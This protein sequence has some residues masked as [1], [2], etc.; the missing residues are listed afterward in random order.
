MAFKPTKSQ[1][2]AIYAS[3]GTL[4][5]AAAGSGKTAV[6]AERVVH[7]LTNENPISA[8]RILVVTFMSAAA[9]EMRSR[10]E[11]RLNKEFAANPDNKFIYSQK[12][13]LNNAKICTIDSFCID[14][15]REHF[16]YFEISPDFKIGDDSSVKKISDSVLNEILNEEFE[17]GEPEFLALLNALCSRFDETDLKSAIIGLYDFSENLPFPKVWLKGLS[18]NLNREEYVAKIFSE[19]FGIINKK[20][21]SALSKMNLALDKIL[22]DDDLKDK[23][24]NLFLEE[25]DFYEKLLSISENEDWDKLYLLLDTFSYGRF[26]TSKNIDASLINALKDLRDSSKSLLNEIKG[27]VYGKKEEVAK[28][29]LSSLN[30]AVKLIEL[31]ARYSEKFNRRCLEANTL[32]FSQAEHFA[33]NLLCENEGDEVKLTPLANDIVSRFDEVLVDEFQDINDMQDLLFNILSKNQKNLFVVGD[34]KQSIYK[35]RG[36][37]PENFLRKQNSYVPLEEANSEDFK[38]IILENNFRSRKGI[39]D[40]VNFVFSQI[41]NGE[42]SSVKYGRDE[43]LVNSAVYPESRETETEVHYIDILSDEYSAAELEAQHIANLIKEYKQNGYISDNDSLKPANFSDFAIILRGLKSKGAIYAETLRKN[44]IP[45]KFSSVS[46]LDS[47]EVKIMLSLLTVIANPSRDIELVSVLMSPLFNFTADEIALIKAD[48]KKGTMISAIT[49][50]ALC[51]NKKAADF[52]DSLN[53]FRTASLTLGI[54]DLIDYLYDATCLPD[55]ISALDQGRIRRDN[56]SKLYLKALEYEENSN[57]KNILRFIDYIESIKETETGSMP[58]GD[59]VTITTIHKSKGLQFPICIIS[60]TLKRFSGEDTRKNLLSDIDYGVAF[61]YFDNQSNEKREALQF[62]VIKERMINSSY[63]EEMRLLYVA[64]TRAKEKLIIVNSS[65]KID[66]KLE[67]A[68]GVYSLSNNL[69]QYRTILEDSNS[70]F[71]WVLKT[72][73]THKEFSLANREF[74]DFGFADFNLKFVKIKSDEI[75]FFEDISTV[76]TEGVAD[77]DLS[78]KIKDII[79]FKYPYE[80]VR[81]IISKSSVTAIAHKADTKDYSF[82]ALPDFMSASG[83]SAA[84]RGTAT[85]RFMQFCDFALAEKDVKAELDRLYEWEFISEAEHDA[86][87]IDSVKKFFESSIYKRIKNSDYRREMRFI[88]EI[89]AGRFDNSLPDNVK[90]EPVVIQGSVDLVFEENGK[91]IIL[92]FKTDRV[93]D[94]ERLK[95]AYS[96]QL[97]IYATACEQ[98]LGKQVSDCLLYSFKLGRTIKI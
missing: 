54:G 51:G 55:V 23:Y 28:Q 38:K 11:A 76:T 62:K 60:D 45:V 81:N 47:S 82:T 10:I 92:D 70:Y 71:D 59:A 17:G 1:K 46:S 85:H 3:S 24:E 67:N 52:I 72:S 66:E 4:V 84:K 57:S 42:K 35:F 97:N 26:S 53:S 16:D 6:L 98:I 29:I 20:I 37:N 22:S 18:K 94:E 32:T 2:D 73:V 80:A 91:I 36:S 74:I 33:L 8:D 5:G 41:M 83:L 61:K 68:A 40:Y 58:V 64:F 27:I 63:E 93:T 75:E 9:E 7:L 14:L 96:E 65:K 34:V 77:I 48:S 69:E 78:N 44:G 39:C 25:K 88:T 19:A 21:K 12:L 79:S 49:K 43:E 90:N 56:L 95:E 15:V 13:K 86:V 87:D 50:S 31:T 30:L 89:E